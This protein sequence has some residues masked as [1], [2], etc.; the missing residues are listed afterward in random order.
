[1]RLR[2]GAPGAKRSCALGAVIGRLWMAPQL[3]R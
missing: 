2:L 1:M 3:H